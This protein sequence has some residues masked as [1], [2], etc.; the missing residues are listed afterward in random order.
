MAVS[1]WLASRDERLGPARRR[2]CVG[3]RGR[4]GGAVGL[5]RSTAGWRSARWASSRRSR[6]SRRRSRSWSAIATG[7][8]P[9]AVQVVGDRRRARRG[10]AASREPARARRRPRGGRRAR[11]CSPAPASGSTS[12]FSTPPRTR[13]CPW[14]VVTAR[15]R[16]PRRS[17]SARRSRVGVSVSASSAATLPALVAVGLCDVG[18]NVLFGLATTRGF[19]SVVSVLASLYPVV[20]VVLA[21][22]VPARALA[23]SQRLG[24]AAPLAGAA[25]DRRGLSDNASCQGLSSSSRTRCQTPSSVTEPFAGTVPGK[26]AC[27]WS[28]T[29]A[30]FS[31]KTLPDRAA[32]R[33]GGRECSRSAS[34]KPACARSSATRRGAR[35]DGVKLVAKGREGGA[36]WAQLGGSSA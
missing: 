32:R 13:A 24:V 34:S 10:G 3:G 29:L 7:E 22:V 14:A 5:A 17:R 1:V 6:P 9:S 19:L 25:A 12:S 16:P 21:A 23:A 33:Q 31:G 30:S 11:A 2:C 27:S 18:A 8:R 26:N 28:R 15:G 20:T 36:T 4:P 35:L